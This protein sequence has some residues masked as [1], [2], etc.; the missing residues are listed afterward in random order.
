MKKIRTLAWLLTLCTMIPVITACG[1]DT[2]TNKGDEG[3]KGNNGTA[4]DTQNVEES[5]EPLDALEARKLVSDGLGEYDFGGLTYRIVTSDDKSETLYCEAETGDVIDDAV[6]QRNVAVEDRFHCKIEVVQDGPYADVSS[7][8]TK[9]ITAGEDAFDIASYHVVQLGTLTPSGY[10]LNWYDIPNI[11]FSKPWW[12]PSTVNDLTYNGVCLTAIGDMALSA[13]SA[14]YCVFYNK[15]LGQNLDFPDLYQVV[16][17]GK[18]TIDYITNLTK[19]IY[20][21][22]NGNGSVDLEDDLFGYT[23]DAYSNMNT[24]LW[25]F[26]NPIFKKDGNVLAYSYKT[27]KIPEIVNKICDIFSMYDGIKTNAKHVEANG[28]SHGYGR[29]M[30]AK[31]QSVLA[32]GYISMSLTHFR[33]LKDEF[34]ILP[35]P[36][37]DE[38]QD[39]YHTMA[40]GHHEALAIPKTITNAEAVGTITE[41]M[42]AESYKILVPAY[43]DVALKVKSTRDEQSIQM[44]DLIVNSR[45]FDFGYVYDAWKG[46]SFILQTLVTQKNPNFESYYAKQEKSINKWYN[47]VIEYFDTYEENE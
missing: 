4:A 39:G 3:Q 37:W 21:D 35:Y 20:Q 32:N 16:N 31:G 41:A 30:F 25:A 22:L 38:A 1:G 43:Y 6:F 19:D 29:D 40:D 24:Y 34:G 14:A 23:S 45:M 12:S 7:F 9:A 13:L 5:T 17:D 11:D 44:L 33:D 15:T 28:N 27:E 10:F 18:W 42:C 8:M 2:G 26:D 47:Q 46:A 36:K